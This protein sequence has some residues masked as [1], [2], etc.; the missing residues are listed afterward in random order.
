MPPGTITLLYRGTRCFSCGKP[1][2][3]RNNVVH[4]ANSLRDRASNSTH[5]LLSRALL[6][7]CRSCVREAVCIVDQVQDFPETPTAQPFDLG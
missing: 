3:L 1:V 6:V 4:R 7:R 2:H 5:H